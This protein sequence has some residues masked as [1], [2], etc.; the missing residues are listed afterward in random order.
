LVKECF[1]QDM[2]HSGINI[3]MTL[4]LAETYLRA[5]DLR[6]RGLFEGAAALAS[7]TGQW[8][9]AIHPRTGGGCMGDG[10]HGWAIAEW[11]M[12]LRNFFVMEEEG[13]LRIGLGILPE[14]LETQR[15]L[16]YGPT[17]T[18]FGSISVVI[19]G[20]KETARVSLTADWSG[21]AQPAVTA[22]LPGCA[23]KRLEPPDYSAIVERKL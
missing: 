17:L 6:F 9:E 8:P 3:Y 12:L 5:G 16:V 19:E 18:P 10:Q 14:W 7:P 22:C 1:F 13:A 4:E 2:I 23:H 20:Q 11:L 21:D 15:Q